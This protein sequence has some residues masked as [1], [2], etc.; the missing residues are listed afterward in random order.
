M[1]HKKMWDSTLH[2]FGDSTLFFLSTLFLARFKKC[3]IARLKKKMWD[4][5]LHLL[6]LWEHWYK[7][8]EKNLQHKKKN[9]AYQ[10]S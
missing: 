3:T 4:S 10:C 2:Q 1:Q 9:V 7:L 5:T 6:N 8:K